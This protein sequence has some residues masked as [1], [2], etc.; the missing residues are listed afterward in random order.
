M[1]TAAVVRDVNLGWT[2]RDASPLDGWQGGIANVWSS[3][4]ADTMCG[5]V[6]AC[7]ESWLTKSESYLEAD[8]PR[9]DGPPGD[10]WR[11]WK[12]RRLYCRDYVPGTKRTGRDTIDSFAT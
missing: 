7:L 5:I 9:I 6:Y 8:W 2:P 12:L 11:G 1:N 10:G 3:I 4:P